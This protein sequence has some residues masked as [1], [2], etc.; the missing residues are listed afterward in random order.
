MFHDDT[1]RR[2]PPDN[3]RSIGNRSGQGAADNG[4]DN[5]EQWLGDELQRLLKRICELER[6]KSSHDRQMQRAATLE[7]RL[8]ALVNEHQTLA[9]RSQTLEL[10]NEDLRTQLS[11]A[12]R[13]AEER[14]FEC[15]SLREQLQTLAAT[16]ASVVG[17]QPAYQPSGK[18]AVCPPS[19]NQPGPSQVVTAAQA[20]LANPLSPRRTGTPQR[21]P[22]AALSSDKGNESRAASPSRFALSRMPAESDYTMSVR[23]GGTPTIHRNIAALKQERE[24]LLKKFNAMSGPR[25]S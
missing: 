7:M 17:R 22:T 16:L 19:R 1:D 2:A 10:E 4:A 25:V 14:A 6:E 3:Y 23:A 13:E 18:E 11:T 12:E 5:S 20:A 8:S 24:A 21:G 15:S 9:Q